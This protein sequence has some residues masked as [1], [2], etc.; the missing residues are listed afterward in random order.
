MLLQRGGYPAPSF[1]PIDAL[2]FL[3]AISLFVEEMYQW[4]LDWRREVHAIAHM[5]S[6]TE[7]RTMLLYMHALL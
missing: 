3:W 2:F 6:P 4:E 1:S 7:A 5:P